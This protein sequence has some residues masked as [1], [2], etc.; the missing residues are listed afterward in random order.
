MLRSYDRK[1]TGLG[2]SEEFYENK[3]CHS[4]QCGIIWAEL[5]WAV[6]AGLLLVRLCWDEFFPA[7]LIYAVLLWAAFY[8]TSL[9]LD[10]LFGASFFYFGLFWTR[11]YS[12]GLFQEDLTLLLWSWLSGLGSLVL[13]L[14]SWLSG[15]GS[16]V[17]A[18]LG[19]TLLDLVLID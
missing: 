15:L 3:R 4:K 14:W 8:I 5:V 19:L 17:L 18:P 12:D 11:L 10:E 9:I 2:S 13:A 16:L 1:W 6:R 7:S